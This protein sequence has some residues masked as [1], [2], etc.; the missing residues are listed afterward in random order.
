MGAQALCQGGQRLVRR[1]RFLQGVQRQRQRQE[2]QRKERQGQEAMEGWGPEGL[3]E[4]SSP[5][6]GERRQLTVSDL[7]QI[8]EAAHD[9]TTL[10]LG[11]SCLVDALSY[12][13]SQAARTPPLAIHLGL[14]AVKRRVLRVRTSRALLPIPGEAV[15]Q[16]RPVS[17]PFEPEGTLQR[18]RCFLERRPPFRAVAPSRQS[19][20]E[21]GAGAWALNSLAGCNLLAGHHSLLP[22]GRPSALQ[23]AAVGELQATV[24]RSMSRSFELR[25][26][27]KDCAAELKRAHVSYTGEEVEVAQILS[28]EQM[29]P[30]LPPFG[31]GGTIQAVDFLSP[32][33]RFWLE[34]PE[35]LLGDP[36]G[37]SGLK[38]EAKLHILKGQELEVAK[39]LVDRNVCTWLEREKVFSFGGRRLY[40]GMFGV[41]KDALTPSG[42]PVLRTIMNLTPCNSL[43]VP[44]QQ[45]HRELPSIFTWNSI[46]VT[47]SDILEVS[48]S[49]MSSAFYLFALPA[50]WR[51]YFCFAISADGSE[52]GLVKGRRYDL[53]CSCLPMGWHSSVALMQE[54][55]AQVLVSGRLPASHQLARNR[56]I[57]SWLV[58]LESLVPPA[59]RDWWQ[60]YLDNFASGL[61]TNAYDGRSVPPER[62]H[63]WHEEAERAWASA[64]IVSSEKKRVT[65]ART[66]VELGAH[67]DG[68]KHLV[69]GSPERLLKTAKLILFLLCSSFTV[70]ELQTV[71]GR[72]VFLMSFRRPTMA[73]FSK[74]WTYIA[75]PALRHRLLP[76]V[77][78]ELFNALL[79]LPLMFQDLTASI[80]AVVTCSDASHE[81]GATAIAETLTEE[82]QEFLKAALAD[83][84]P[85][86]RQ[87][88]LVVSAFHGIGGASRAYDLLG[89][90]VEGTIV[91]EIDSAANR[92]TSRRW[93]SSEFW[94][95]IRQVDHDAVRALSVRFCHCTRVDFWA[96]FPC[97]DLSSAKFGRRNLEGSESSL[98]FEALRVLRLL[99]ELFPP[100]TVVHHIFENVASM[101]VSAMDEIT[102][103]TGTKPWRL[104][105]ADI[106][107]ISRPR[108]TW[109]SFPRAQLAGIRWQ[110]R[111]GYFEL[112]LS[113]EGI[114]PSQWLRP[115]CLWEPLD[116]TTKF[117]TFMKSIPRV[118]PPPAP[119]GIRR[120]DEGTLSRWEADSFRFPPYHY[121]EPYVIWQGETWRLLHASE[122]ELLL[123][124]GFGHTSLAWGATAVKGDLQG[125]EDKRKSLCGDSFSMLSFGTVLACSMP[126]VDSP[127][128]VSHLVRRLGLAPGFCTGWTVAAPVA[129]RLQFGERSTE[130]A[131]EFPVRELNKLFLQ[132]TNHTGADVQV[133]TGQFLGKSP[134][135]QSVPSCLWNWRFL[136]QNR[137]SRHDHINALEMRQALI[138]LSW[139]LRGGSNFNCRWV[140]LSDSF[141]TISI[142]CKGRTASDKL[143]HLVRRFNATMLVAQVFPI[144]LHVASLDN[145]TDEGSRRFPQGSH[146]STATPP[147]RDT[148]S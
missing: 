121:S 26:A 70:K 62:P 50:Q 103:L 102:T 118:R 66:A 144:L 146:V 14:K 129:R 45:G 91:I 34:H 65:R 124:F 82:G 38:F 53:C 36:A 44:F 117:P 123:G 54:I 135:R 141:V 104:N 88:I 84:H 31:F 20:E 67:I 73:V 21:E 132:R 128:S 30:A 35:R 127:F 76:D 81:G 110:D 133:V 111:G 8:L 11:I 10:G 59:H 93:P 55:S 114:S 109:T 37:F 83:E 4:H 9:T 115:G 79:L 1:G 68:E 43:F 57:P 69:G 39:L 85:P 18:I 77:R 137:W 16:V 119:I 105:P 120:C 63:R 78:R 145:P 95:D 23:L 64:G 60:V 24:T 6:A 28:V 140:H 71:T 17:H 130:W 52:I 72:I 122:R 131:P 100:T 98:I 42:K 136:F 29:K 13:L 5:S 126:W 94:G 2:R 112:E 25:W 33:S 143:E 89:V 125:F 86:D 116:P 107:P 97:V 134:I 3:G 49:D 15:V 96:G 46:V 61:V 147:S 12:E 87:S 48:Q 148:A 106:L 142:L 19:V 108:F 56:L 40:N 51:P 27:R 41:R 58:N 113:G 92:V 47:A 7:G 80:P 101:D 32:G 22:S 74:T 99:R 138:S 75:K 90:Q 139:L